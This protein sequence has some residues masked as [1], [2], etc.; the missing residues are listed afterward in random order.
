MSE[1][2][3]LGLVEDPDWNY[4]SIWAAVPRGLK[5]GGFCGAFC[6]AEARTL[7]VEGRTEQRAAKSGLRYTGLSAIGA[8]R[9]LSS[10]RLGGSQ[11]LSG[12]RRKNEKKNAQVEDP[13]G[14]EKA[15]P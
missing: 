7:Q 9:P 13:Y 15:L 10:G 1:K 6:T 12:T 2:C 14:R 4:G 11:A 5:P 8:G 3:L